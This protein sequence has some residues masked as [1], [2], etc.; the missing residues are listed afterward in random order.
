MRRK[1]QKNLSSTDS[2]KNTAES[3]ENRIDKAFYV[4][5]NE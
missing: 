5:K 4:T 1:K 3:V 2:I